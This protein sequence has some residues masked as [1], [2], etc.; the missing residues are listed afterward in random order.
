[1]VDEGVKV[2]SEKTNDDIKKMMETFQE[3]QKECDPDGVIEIQLADEFSN[4]LPNENAGAV[5]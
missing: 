4:L 2:I 1:L 3:N 5:Q